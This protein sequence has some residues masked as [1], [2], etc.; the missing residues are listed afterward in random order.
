ML[1]ILQVRPE[2]GGVQY[3]CT[4]PPLSELRVGRTLLTSL[5]NEKCP[6]TSPLPQPGFPW[7]GYYPQNTTKNMYSLYF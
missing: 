6:E 2:A 7:I 4:P 3:P 5:K 1:S